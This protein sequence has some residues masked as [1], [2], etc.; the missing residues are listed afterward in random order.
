MAKIKLKKSLTISEAFDRF[1]LSKK[2]EGLTNKTLTTYKGHLSCIAHHLNIFQVLLD[3]EKTYLG[4][5][6]EDDFEKDVRRALSLPI[7]KQLVYYPN[8]NE[9]STI[10]IETY[11]IAEVFSNWWTIT[12][13][14][15][16]GDD[17]KIHNLYLK[18]MQSPTFVS[19]MQKQ[20]L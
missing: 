1:L 16:N 6:P 15:E 18:E 7:T 3:T 14:L 17:V 2:S 11:K 19:D 9:N 10:N 20:G 12:I 5:A 13:H 8:K 4:K